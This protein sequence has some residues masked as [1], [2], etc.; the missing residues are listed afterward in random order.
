MIV[1]EIPC[2]N[3]GK[4]LRIGAHFLVCPGEDGDRA[5]IRGAVRM[6]DEFHIRRP[7]ADKAW[8]SPAC[9]TADGF[10]WMPCEKPKR[11]A[12]AHG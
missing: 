6:R 8:C 11:E 10:P 3:C 5:M 2:Q 12:R 9:A 4:T 1:P 7:V